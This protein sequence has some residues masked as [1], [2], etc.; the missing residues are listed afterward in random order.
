MNAITFFDAG[1][2]LTVERMANRAT[3]DGRFVRMPCSAADVLE[4]LA[5]HGGTPVPIA[6]IRRQL[7]N[8]ANRRDEPRDP[9][10]AVYIQVLKLRRA[11]K[12]TA[13]T[14]E[15]CYGDGYRLHLQPNHEGRHGR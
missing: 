6:R 1:G 2:R 8:E 14:I 3:I 10:R 13:A 7:W 12:R 11:L 5:R 4:L 9:V 15:T